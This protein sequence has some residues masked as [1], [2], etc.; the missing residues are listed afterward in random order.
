MIISAGRNETFPFSTS[1]GV[2]LIE[3]SINLTR[4]CL[5]NKPEYLLFIGSAGSYGDFKVFDIVES[6]KSSNIELGFLTQSAYTPLD[7]VIESDNNFVKNDTIVNSS[8]YISTDDKLTKEFLDYG[9][10]IENMEFFSVL[11]VAKEFKIPVAGIFVVT[12][13]TNKDAHKDFLEN[14]KI[15]MDKLTNYLVQK[16]IIKIKMGK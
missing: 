13:Y 4:M 10:G 16:D 1:I 9:V 15:A 8:N 12:N 11:S 7:N 2:G 14:H 3:T 5:F 6:K